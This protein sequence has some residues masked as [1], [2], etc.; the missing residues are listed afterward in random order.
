MPSPNEPLGKP[1]LVP[2]PTILEQANAQITKALAQVPP[3]R[4]A[5]VV[6]GVRDGEIFFGAAAR[7]N[8]QWELAADFELE[9]NQKPDAQFSV[10]WSK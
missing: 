4:R 7:I 3:G 1:T 9:K 2:K 5:A 6:A 8:D 10:R